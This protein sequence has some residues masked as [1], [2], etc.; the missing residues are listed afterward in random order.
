MVVRPVTCTTNGEGPDGQPP[1]GS[2]WHAREM[3]VASPEPVVEYSRQERQQP[4]SG[5]GLARARPGPDDRERLTGDDE[6][7]GAEARLA[8]GQSC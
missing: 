1:G 8:V 7:L 6:H 5:E 2:A 3:G 4:G